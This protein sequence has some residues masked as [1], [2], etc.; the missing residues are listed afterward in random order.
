M[1]L[2]EY[3]QLSYDRTL[4]CGY[5]FLPLRFHVVQGGIRSSN[6]SPLLREDSQYPGKRDNSGGFQ[7]GIRELT[8][9]IRRNL[10]YNQD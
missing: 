7:G 3:M 5:E 6:H 2:H 4:P 10:E 1:P 9:Q 8:G